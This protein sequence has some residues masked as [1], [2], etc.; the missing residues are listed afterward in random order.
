MDNSSKTSGIDRLCD[1]FL[2]QI[3][4]MYH[5]F[6]FLD[7]KILH[8][9]FISYCISLYG[10]EMCC[11]VLESQKQYKSISVTCHKAIK[12]VCG[13]I[14]RDTSHVA[15]ANMNL[16]IFKHLLAKRCNIFFLSVVISESRCLRG[17]KYYFRV[18]S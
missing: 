18:D 16:E 1:P 6:K 3:N 9:L 17:L 15:C 7:I 8:F 2:R 14:F 4:G 13:M 5:K 12:Q 10:I 11:D